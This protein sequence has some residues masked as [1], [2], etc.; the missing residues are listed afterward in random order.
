MYVIRKHSI[1]LF[2]F[3]S[4]CLS[5]R[6]KQTCNLLRIPV[7]TLLSKSW[8]S[9][10]KST[11][12][13]ILYCFSKMYFLKMPFKSRLVIR[14]NVLLLM[15]KLF[16]LADILGSS[17]S[18]SLKLLMFSCVHNRTYTHGNINN[19]KEKLPIYMSVAR[20]SCQEYM[21]RSMQDNTQRTTYNEQHTAHNT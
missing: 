3:P 8:F 5:F 14:L 17:I 4:I 12:I 16:S 9:F 10:S 6:W 1:F 18:F 15:F 21:V 13:I 19:F 20:V 2:P 11:S 7:L